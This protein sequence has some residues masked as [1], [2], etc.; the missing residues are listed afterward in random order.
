MTTLATDFLPGNLVRARGREWVVQSD[1]CL[2]DGTSALRLRPLGGTDDD[3]ITLLPELELE[4]LHSAEFD[5]PNPAQPGNHGAALLLRDAL[6]LKLRAGAGPFRSFGNIAVEPRAYQLVP[7]LMALRLPTVRL[8]IGDDVGVG[9]TIEAALIVRELMDRGEV[10]RVAVLCPP[11]LV[12]QWQGELQQRFNM[13]AV[14]LTAASASRLERQLPHGVGLF[15]HHPVVVVSLDYIKSERHREHFLSIAP[16]CIVVD[17]AHTCSASGAGKQ[18]RFEL[19]K[20][21]AADDNRHLLLLTAT[22]HSGDEVAFFNLLS[23]LNPAFAELQHRTSKDDPLRDQLARQ[24]VQRRRK[25]IAE[26]QAATQDGPG[27]PRRM[28]A[29]LTYRLSGAWG[30]FFDDVQAHCR[31]LAEAVEQSGNQGGA[32]LIWYATLALLRCVASSP[33]AAAKALN[34]RLEGRLAA[35][36]DDNG[37]DAE[38]SDLHDGAAEDLTILDLEPAAQLQTQAGAQKLQALIATAERLSG[39][40]GD[41]KLAALVAHIGSLLKDGFAP[42]VFCR[43]VTTAHYVAAELR[44]HFPKATIESITGELA[45]EERR[46]RIDQMG[47]GLAD[48]DNSA[49]RVLVA[50]DCL[51]EGINLQHLFT[52]V[53]HYDLAWNPTRHEQREGRVDRYGQRAPEVRCTM[54]YGQDNPVDGFVLKVILRKGDAIQKELGVLVPMPEDRLRINQA[55]V[56]AALMRRPT[57]ASPQLGFDFGDSEQI[58]APLQTQWQDALDKARSNRT[59]FAQRGVHP[60][61]VLPEWHKQQEAL[62]SQADVQRFLASACARLNAPLEAH[63]G[64]HRLHPQ[65]LPEALRLRLADEGLVPDGSTKPLALDLAELHRSHPL[66]SVLAEY[67]IETALQGDSTLAARCAATVTSGVDRV[68]T[69]VLLRLRHQL[70]YQQRRLPAPRSGQAQPAPQGG[71]SQVAEP[72]LLGTF[73][74]LA[75]ECVALAIRGRHNPEWL[76]GPEAARLLESPPAGNLPREAA[77]REVAKALEA[78]QA[79][80]PRLEALARQRATELLQDHE[81]VRQASGRRVGAGGGQHQVQACLPVDVVGVYVLLPDSL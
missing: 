10:Q 31:E 44:K 58:L 36:G 20:R 45:P 38:F 4:P 23:L 22:P 63:R 19:L 26:W 11:H 73:Q 28:K 55:L 75:E 30:S 24:F 80:R 42:V 3:V 6:R 13:P 9:K 57:G 41:P 64:L 18:L 43:Y 50:T 67:L 32:R 14:A 81:R 17:E 68:T 69:I 79:E 34:T 39:T 35:G 40:G 8:L 25:D 61:E 78:L 33:A 29:E 72:H 12:E 70:A 7:L 16:E 52:A 66:V 15:D 46:E 5:A 65:H 49:G 54:L 2:A 27:F 74:M 47:E 56:K 71:S 21:L 77:Q 1:N 51:S 62:G 37:D 59:V 53:V 48:A 76:S 60:A